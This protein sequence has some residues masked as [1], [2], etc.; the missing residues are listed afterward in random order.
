ML[1][2]VTALGLPLMISSVSMAAVALVH[3]LGLN[4]ER[5]RLDMGP[6][7]CASGALSRLATEPEAERMATLGPLAWQPE[8]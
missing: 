2:V 6:A 7:P 3:E 4:Q 1:V 5:W 8:P